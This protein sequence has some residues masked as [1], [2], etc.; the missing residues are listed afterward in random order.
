ML[1][2]DGISCHM[3]TPN[4]SGIITIYFFVADQRL[5]CITKNTQL[6]LIFQ[7]SKAENKKFI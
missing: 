6:F 5:S 1:F 3:H 4:Y 2:I 7:H